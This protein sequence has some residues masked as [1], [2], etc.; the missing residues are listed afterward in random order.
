MTFLW[1]DIEIG[2]TSNPD[3]INELGQKVE[4]LDALFGAQFQFALKTVDETINNVGALQNDDVLFAPVVANATYDVEIWLLQNTN[5]AANFRLDLALPAGAVWQSG[6][7]D[8]NNTQIGVMTTNAVAGITGTGA[9]AYVMLKSAFV[10]GS[11]SGTAQL[12]W[13]QNTAHASNAIVRA[14]SRLKLTRV[15]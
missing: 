5:A 8:C 1:T 12:R 7:F 4:E 6:H 10:V 11:T 13:S 2:F 9:D 14:G 3:P 15:V